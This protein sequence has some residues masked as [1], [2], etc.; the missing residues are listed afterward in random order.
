MVGYVWICSDTVGYG[1]IHLDSFGC[2]WI[3]LDTLGYAR[4]HF[5]TRDTYPK[6]IQIMCILEGQGQRGSSRGGRA[7]AA[8]AAAAEICGSAAAGR[9]WTF[10]NAFG[11]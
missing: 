5:A 4:I 11:V 9:I 8:A 3:C 7:A 1:R 2:G 10:L 6:W